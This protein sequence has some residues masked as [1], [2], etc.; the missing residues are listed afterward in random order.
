MMARSADRQAMLQL[1]RRSGMNSLW[2]AGIQRVLDGQTSIEELAAH[3]TP[4]VP[5]AA[6]PQGDIDALLQQL[7]P[8]PRAGEGAAGSAVV[9]PSAR[10]SMP[11]MVRPP[12]TGAPGAPVAADT[13]AAEAPRAAR[14]SLAR[15][16]MA[17]TIA[18]RQSGTSDRLRL[19]VVHEEHHRR[20]AMRR[21]F[22]SV[23]CIVLEAADGESAL[24]FASCLRP[25]AVV[26]EVVLPKLNGVGLAQAL[27]AEQIVEHVFVCTDQRDELMLQWVVGVGVTD[28]IAADDDTD[29]IAARIVR[30]LPQRAHALKVV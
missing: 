12:V 21:A 30:Q 13:E 2:D 29:V 18:P 19:L 11:A 15:T 26:T 6:M 14:A 1:A 10:T 16:S 9:E 7:L 3:V 24:T 25:D 23:G 8:K 20:R 17:L 4:P 5:V 27:L 28:V 22:E